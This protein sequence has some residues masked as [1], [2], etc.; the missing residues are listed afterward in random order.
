MHL[1]P[2]V[3][4]A[5]SCCVLCEARAHFTR[6]DT[7]MS[8]RNAR[9]APSL[10]HDKAVL[11]SSPV[12]ILR[13]PEARSCWFGVL[14]AGDIHVVHGPIRPCA[15]QGLCEQLCIFSDGKQSQPLRGSFLHSLFFGDSVTL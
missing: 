7:K 14:V 12:Q 5:P 1:V 8:W 11:V 10:I 9:D 6:S 15:A 4:E 2:G 13:G 3:D